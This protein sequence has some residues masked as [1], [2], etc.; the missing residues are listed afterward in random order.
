MKLNLNGL[1]ISDLNLI[2]QNQYVPWH[3]FENSKILIYG[4]T[5]F[6][7][8]WLTTA[9]EHANFE[10]GLNIEVSIVTRDARAA[11]LLSPCSQKGGAVSSKPAPA[12]KNSKAGAGFQKLG[13]KNWGQVLFFESLAAPLGPTL[14]VLPKSHPLNPKK[15]VNLSHF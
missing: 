11:Q 10:L 3:K 13:S 9:L 15:T 7:G 2:A 12:C 14:P 4:G 5:G 6:I 1:S 8:S